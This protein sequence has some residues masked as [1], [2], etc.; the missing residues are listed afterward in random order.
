M[1]QMGACVLLKYS[2]S[3]IPQTREGER[4]RGEERRGEKRG[5]RREGEMQRGG[6]EERV[7]AC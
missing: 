4:E 6:G 2:D 3:G 5:R 1:T 7:G